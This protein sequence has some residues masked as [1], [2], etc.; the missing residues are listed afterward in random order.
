M[1][2]EAGQALIESMLAI[3]LCLACAL[4]LVDCGIVVRE[5][6]VV[7]QAA[8]RV[9]GAVLA[10]DDPVVAARAAT[11]AGQRRSLDIQVAPSRIRVTIESR[12]RIARAVGRPISQVSIVRLKEHA[13]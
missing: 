13:R 5:R 12:A 11:P 2:R 9:A 3:P 10:G 4:A 1:R 6:I 7:A 8:S